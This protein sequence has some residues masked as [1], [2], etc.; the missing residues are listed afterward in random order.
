MTHHY[1]K[2]HLNLLYT[3]TK[4]K[5]N[6]FVHKV[7]RIFAWS[8][9]GTF[10]PAILYFDLGLSLSSVF[11][12]FAV[13]SFLGAIFSIPATK[14]VSKY[15]TRISMILGILA[16]IPYLAL[17][18]ITADIPMLLYMIPV[19]GGMFNGFFFTAF[20]YDFASLSKDKSYGNKVAKLNIYT[21]LATAFAP[22]IGGVVSQYYSVHI[23]LTIASLIVALS[24]IPLI[25]SKIKH[26]P[27]ELIIKKCFN[28]EKKS[29]KNMLI[30]N[31]SASFGNSVSNVIWP[32]IMFMVLKDYSKLGIVVTISTLSIIATMYF[33]GKYLNKYRNR[34][35]KIAV[36]IEE[37]A[38]IG[39][40]LL[41]FFGWLGIMSVTII[42]GLQKLGQSTSNVP[43]LQEFYKEI[44]HEDDNPA[45]TILIRTFSVRVV[46]AVVYSLLALSLYFYN[47]NEIVLTLPMIMLVFIIPL[48]LVLVRK[49]DKINCKK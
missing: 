13:K 38:W 26:K 14:I 46:E 34:I 30:S 20:D 15:G 2:L 9:V 42:R 48:Q 33:I 23:T 43:I 16:M 4:N 41:Y 5:T 40:I 19:F 47:N 36:A 29:R 6:L 32:L 7:I 3:D 45:Y 44:T 24:I 49:S 31:I 39:S 1:E 22:L 17:L 11:V 35:L 10:L 21:T 27:K 18:I 25:A 28:L 8:L 12:F 37:V